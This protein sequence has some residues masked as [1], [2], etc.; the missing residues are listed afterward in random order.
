LWR[1]EIHEVGPRV[2]GYV[3]RGGTVEVWRAR[4]LRDCDR[5]DVAHRLQ[6]YRGRRYGWWKIGVHALERAFGGRFVF[7]RLL[8]WDRYPI[9][10]WVAA[11]AF[12]PLRHHF[13]GV[14]PR[15]AQPDDIHDCVLAEPERFERVARFSPGL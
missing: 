2:E 13:F 9:C 6:K 14:D 8:R 11:F 10:S 12:E 3:E 1:V 15:L 4:G 5:V 7:R